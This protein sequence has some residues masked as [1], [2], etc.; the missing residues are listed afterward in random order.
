VTCGAV[1]DEAMEALT[2]QTEFLTMTQQPGTSI[3]VHKKKFDDVYKSYLEG[4]GAKMS[5]AQV[6]VRFLGSLDASR[7]R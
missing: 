6:V 3:S 2:L 4:G 5:D 7:H 1:R